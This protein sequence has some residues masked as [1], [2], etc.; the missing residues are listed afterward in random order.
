VEVFIMRAKPVVGSFVILAILILVAVLG[1]PIV[2]MLGG[3]VFFS[4][5]TIAVLRRRVVRISPGTALIVQSRLHDAVLDV[6]SGPKSRFL[7]PFCEK[8]GPL[9]DTGDQRET[10]Y[11]SDLLQHGQRS[12]PFAL[13][14][15]IMYRL[16]PHT[17]LPSRIG[18]ILPDLADNLRGV[19]QFWVDYY[20]RRLV[21]SLDLAHSHNGDH[22][23]LE[24]R[25]RHLLADRLAQFGARIQEV[26]LLVQAPVGLQETLT[27]A[28]QERV[29]T[30]IR[31]E[32]LGAVLGTLRGKREEADSLARLGLSS[33]W[34]HR[35]QVWT[36]LDLASL[37]SSD[38]T[39]SDEVAVSSS[40]QLPLLVEL[41]QPF[42]RSRAGTVVSDASRKVALVD[43][44]RLGLLETD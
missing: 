15:H 23:R 31:A 26:R 36:T 37:L 12:T 6:V 39:A 10:V 17:L 27:L 11:I 14:A 13:K 41:A 18:E 43:I 8:A 9:L 40:E 35:G 16:A 7:L 33:A 5:P 20:L 25:L 4:I 38:D 34:G 30:I 28:E 2:A 29:G 19:L 1:A 32:R 21:A 42:R 22:N 3:L 44:R 24:S